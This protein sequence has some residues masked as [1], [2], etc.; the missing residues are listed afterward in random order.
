VVGLLLGVP[1]TSKPDGYVTWATLMK[2]SH[3]RDETE[4]T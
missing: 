3:D 2:N 4:L 1:N